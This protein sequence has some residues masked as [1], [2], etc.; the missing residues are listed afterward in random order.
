M[1]IVKLLKI[2]TTVLMAPSVMSR[3]LLAEA[4]A[5]GNLVTIERVGKKHPAKEHDFGD[6]KNPHAERASFALLLHVLEMV[7]QRRVACLVFVASC[8]PIS[9]S[10]ILL[11][12]MV[13]C[14]L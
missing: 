13:R 6:Q 9:Q 10:M 5:A 8:L 3:W 1:A 4:K 7:L 14:R 2:S 11:N 12:R